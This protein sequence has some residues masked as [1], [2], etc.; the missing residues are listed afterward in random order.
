MIN[1]ISGARRKGRTKK[2]IIDNVYEL[3]VAKHEYIGCFVVFVTA[4]CL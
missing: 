3:L 2:A 4:G 1:L